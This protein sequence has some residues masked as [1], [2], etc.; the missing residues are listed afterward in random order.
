MGLEILGGTP[1]DWGR[2][3]AASIGSPVDTL[4]RQLARRRLLLYRDDFEA[5]IQEQLGIIFRDEAVRHKFYRLARLAGASSFLKRISDEVARPVYATPPTRRI[6]PAATKPDPRNRSSDAEQIK[7]NDLAKSVGLNRSMD[8]AARLIVACAPVFIIGRYIEDEGPTI[9]LATG[10]CVSVVVDPRKRTRALAIA[11][12]QAPG[13]WVV[14]DD[15]RA[16]TVA[17]GGLASTVQPHD[18]GRIPVVEIHRRGRWGTYWDTQGQDLEVAALQMMFID[19]V[20]LKKHKSQSHIQLAF[21]GDSDGIPKNQIADEDSILMIN[22]QGNLTPIDLQGDPSG[23]LKTKEVLETSVAANYGISR[24]RLNQGKDATDQ[25]LNERTAEILSI[26]GE[27]EE[28][29][30]DLLQRLSKAGESPIVDGL[31]F[32]VDYR[33]MSHRMDPMEELAYWK[34][35]RAN[36]L[37]SIVDDALALNPELDTEAEAWEEITRNM[38][39]EAVYITQRRALNIAD[40]ASVETPGQ[41]PKTNG[42]MGPKVKSGEMTR[43]EAAAQAKDGPPPKSDSGYADEESLARKFLGKKKP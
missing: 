3:I 7:F 19:A 16:F 40:D 29:T 30:Y 8:L 35:L 31:H 10:D 13:R 20:I 9:D 42:A 6:R 23:L 26:M 25:P 15:K 41:N 39:D 28:D 43:D 18:M 21:A 37:R 2:Q 36:G 17:N 32:A 5:V 12:E 38:A 34:E 33:A 11:Y 1:D 27:A 24:S 22:G 4:R 14:V